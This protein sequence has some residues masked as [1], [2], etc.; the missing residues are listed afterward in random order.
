MGVIS[1]SSLLCSSTAQI[2]WI[3]FHP[4]SLQQAMSFSS[5][6]RM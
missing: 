4:P 1:I 3:Q 6:L 5:L 2:P